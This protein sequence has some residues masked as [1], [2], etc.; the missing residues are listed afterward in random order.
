MFIQ[1]IIGNQLVSIPQL[2]MDIWSVKYVV[3]IWMLNMIH[4]LYEC[5]LIM[6]MTG[7][8]QHECSDVLIVT[9]PS[10]VLHGGLVGGPNIKLV[11]H[12]ILALLGHLS[13]FINNVD[14]WL[15]PLPTFRVGGWPAARPMAPCRKRRDRIHLKASPQ[16]LPYPDHATYSGKIRRRKKRG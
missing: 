7:L 5:G 15:V 9:C 4:V 8:A 11:E 1:K 2:I 10:S 6:T 12:Y 14:R 13:I 3:F 16:R